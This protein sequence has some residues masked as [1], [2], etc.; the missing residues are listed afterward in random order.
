MAF[1]SLLRILLVSGLPL[2]GLVWSAAAAAETPVANAVI[3]ASVDSISSP[4]A[5]EGDRPQSNEPE[6]LSD[7]SPVLTPSGDDSADSLLTPTVSESADSEEA[8]VAQGEPS[9]GDV[10]DGDGVLRFTVTGTRNPVPVD[11]L[12]STVT[13][14]ERDDW[15]FYEADGLQELLRYEPGVSVDGSLQRYGAQDINI[16]GIEG[17][18]VL[19]QV[20]NIRLPESFTFGGLPPGGFRIGRADYVDFASLQAIEV[21]RGP[22]STLYGSDALGGVVSY[23]SLRPSDILE[24]EDDTFAADI[25]TTYLSASGGFNNVGRFAGRLGDSA[26]GVFVV[27]RRDAREIDNF[28]PVEFSNS[29]DTSDTNVFTNLVYEINDTSQVNV[30][31]ED[32]NRSS[33][34]KVAQGNRAFS[35][36][37]ASLTQLRSTGENRIERT[38]LSLAYEY[39]DPD[40]ESFLQFARAQIYYQNADTTEEVSEIRPLGS[41]RLA[42]E[43]IRRDSFNEFTSDSYGADI[44][45]RSDFETGAAQHRVTYGIDFSQTEN[46]RPRDRTQTGLISGITT[47]DFGISGTFPEEDFASGDTLR[48]GLYAQDEISVGDFEIIAG[49]RFDYYDLDTSNSDDFNGEAVDLD[50]S[51]LSPRVALLYRATPELS[52]YGQYARGF[53]APLYSEITSGFTNFAFG[54]ETI[55]SPD[56]EPETSNS[57]E[58]GIRGNY[59]Q[60]D[61]GITGFYNTYDNFIA[62]GQLVGRRQ[63]GPD[64]SINQFQTINVDGA[65]IYGVEVSAEYRFSP[66]AYG[67]SLL[68]SLSYTVGDD[69]ESDEP[70]NTIDPL[71]AVVGLRYTSPDDIWRA[72]FIGTFAGEART[73]DGDQFVPDGYAVFDLIGSYNPTSNFGVN[74]GIYN[75]FNNEYYQ[76]SEVRNIGVQDD[77]DGIEQYTQPGL[78]VRLGINVKF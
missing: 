38:R 50:A 60:F 14:F 59:P 49:L 54:Y 27:S 22:A 37:R 40:S 12:P 25:S 20:D 39:D 7:A 32:I 62:T 31:F 58:L 3:K 72:E 63:I 45:L 78:N 36:R 41:A 10:A 77:D 30:I 6:R 61:F 52:I 35:A 56:L 1:S 33:K 23:R 13:V 55:S 47:R 75:L 29:I 73:P 2:A 70:L 68:G 67:L 46:S 34:Y 21:L 44:Q 16:R 28:G 66:E 8:V 11:D 43:P 57:F 5:V 48:L 71:K 74:L 18:R 19:F 51:A 65:R 69:L 42:E 15:E 24:D 4:E 76:Y 64:R 53:R 9:G 26:S 17:N